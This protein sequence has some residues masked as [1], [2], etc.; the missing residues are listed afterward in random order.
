VVLDDKGRAVVTL[1]KYFAALT[2][3]EDATV[4]LTPIGKKLFIASYEWNKKFTAFTVYG[5]QDRE[6]SYVV[7]ADRDD[8]AV[9]RLGRPVE[10]AK[11]NGNFEKGKYLNYPIRL[12]RING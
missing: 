5:E 7:M 8:P 1:P 9:H 12:L 3:E 4:T 10:E 6:V 11:G 2:K